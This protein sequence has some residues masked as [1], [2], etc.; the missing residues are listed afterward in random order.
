MSIKMGKSDL[1]ITFSI[2][3]LLITGLT[4]GLFSCQEMTNFEDTSKEGN[5]G[6]GIKDSTFDPDGIV[7]GGIKGSTF[8]PGGIVGGAEP[9]VVGK[10]KS[11]SGSRSGI[12]LQDAYDA[13]VDIDIPLT[14]SVQRTEGRKVVP[15]LTGAAA[16]FNYLKWT[17][18]S[19]DAAAILDVVQSGQP[20]LYTMCPTVIPLRVGTA[21]VTV[22]NCNSKG[23]PGALTASFRVDVVPTYS[24]GGIIT[25]DPPDYS[26]LKDAVVQIISDEVEG[27]TSPDAFSGAYRFDFLTNGTYTVEVSLAGY[28]SGT[29]T[30]IVVSSGHVPGKNLT[31]AAITP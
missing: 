8:D 17:I 20:A 12:M 3:A 7:G 27:K 16:G 30:G 28:A 18:E 23:V 4:M 29:I 15:T 13:V 5:P 10:E 2:L 21:T 22:Q 9:E 25:L 11:G 19:A 26:L 24:I 1:I 6:G 14:V 31:L